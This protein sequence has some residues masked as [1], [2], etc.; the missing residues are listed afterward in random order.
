MKIW[1]ALTD[2]AN[3]VYEFAAS[4]RR[5]AKT[6]DSFN[7]Q[8]GSYLLVNKEPEVILPAL[9]HEG[10]GRGKRKLVEAK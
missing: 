9:E 4:V 8:A 2:A 1:S 5:L 3:A 10:N 7:E 6:V